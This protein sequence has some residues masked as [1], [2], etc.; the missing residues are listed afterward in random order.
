MAQSSSSR[1]K[2]L[3]LTSILAFLAIVCGILFWRSLHIDQ[4]TRDWVVRSLSERFD[5]KV[6]LDSLHVSAF[7]EMSVEGHNLTIY[8]RERTDLS[9]MQIDQF[10]FHLGVLGI[11]RVPHEIRGVSVKNMTITVPPR[12]PHTATDRAK[13]VNAPAPEKKQ[14][15]PAILVDEIVCKN[16][17]LR[18]WPK[19]AGNFP[20]EGDIPA[21]PLFHAG[22]N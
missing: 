16:P 5:T 7:P 2:W 22:E 21:L 4:F 9:F 20:L 10:T 15:L 14:A 3:I 8:H 17:M 11:F 18:F 12:A 19:R 13:D 6:T 1:G